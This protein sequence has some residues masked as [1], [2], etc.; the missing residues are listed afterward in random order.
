MASEAVREGA[1]TANVLVICTA[2]RCRSPLAHGILRAS[3]GAGIALRSAG[4]MAIPGL[5]PLL[6]VQ[7][8]ASANG[9]D[10]SDLRSTPLTSALVT[11]ADHLLVME[12]YHVAIVRDR[13]GAHAAARTRLLGSFHPDAALRG[14]ID[15]PVGIGPS[16]LERCFAQVEACCRGFL[17]ELSATEPDS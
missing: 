14:E 3:C 9:I 13:F 10:V 6:E 8:L 1:V 7:E 2:N 17:R 16:A 11:W 12:G 15:D 5:P 4:V